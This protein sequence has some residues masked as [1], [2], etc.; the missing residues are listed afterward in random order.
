[1]KGWPAK[2]TVGLPEYF[3]RGEQLSVCHG[4]IMWGTRAIVPPKLRS[5]VPEALHE[6]H[7]GVVKMKSLSRSYIW[8]PGI[9]HQIEDLAKTCSGCQLAQ[10]QPPLAPVHS[11]EWPTAP[12]Q[13]IHVDYAGPF[14]DRMFLVVVDAYSKWSEVFIVKNATSTKTVEV[15]RTL[16]ARTGLPERLVSDNGQFTSE[17]FQSLVR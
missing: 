5:R 2:N 11:W 12:W 10:K 13:R 4:C 15:L 7:M 9:D 8:R 1:M 6:G 16:F 3:S 14:L 17:E